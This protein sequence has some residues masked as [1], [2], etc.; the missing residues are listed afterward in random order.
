MVSDIQAGTKMKIEQFIT[1]I[2]FI[3]GLFASACS[4]KLATG[5]EHSIP[6]KTYD[7]ATFDYIYADGIRQKSL[8]NLGDALND[9]EQCLRLNSES[10]ATN[11]EISQIVLGNGDVAN[12]KKYLKR[13]AELDPKNIWYGVALANLYYQNR[14]IDSAVLCYE[15]LIKIYP[16][17][18]N[19]EISLAG[20]YAENK[21]Y[22]EARSILEKFDS[23]YGANE[24]TTLSLVRILIEEKRYQEALNKI[25]D[26]IVQKP[27]DIVYNGIAAEIYRMQGDTQKASDLYSD[28]IKRNPQDPGIQLSLC[29]FLLSKK[30]LDEM[31]I[32]L[33]TIML[34]NEITREQ[35][36]GLFSGL[37][38]NPEIIEKYGK[39][40]EM[41]LMVLEAN[42][43]DDDI[44]ILMRPDFLQKER[45]SE[46]AA[47]RLEEIIGLQPDNYLAW[48]RLLLVYYEM[49]NFEVL[50]K[51]GKECATKFNRSILAK[52]LYANAAMENEEFDTALEELRKA[53]IL[54]GDSKDQE[55]QVLTMRAD[56]YYRMKDFSQAFDTFDKALAVNDTD[57]TV[58]NNYAYYLAEQ[59]THLKDAEKMAKHVIERARSNSTFLDTY[60]WIL[61]KRGKTKEAARIMENIIGAGE[62]KDA[63]YYEHYGFILRRMGKCSEAIKQW[64]NALS[65]DKTKSNLEKEIKDCEK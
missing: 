29:D 9:F 44:I 38:A 48:E 60:A 6:G 39:K 56:I 51:R 42:Y 23:K 64:E 35:K 24:N 55:L 1:I 16:E 25:N 61:Y 14:N 7:Q 52:I 10:D 62:A 33:N 18:E 37:I 45:K 34:N 31:F 13:A 57:L 21:K 63:E 22:N 54:A 49:K 40:M 59:N 12:G 46:D 36:I 28:L 27:N 58:L 50:E 4:K 15:R 30:D 17:K 20:L 47:K 65:L 19:I 2:I 3:S 26:L 43:K 8:G 53:E 41:A 32:L 5:I 11:Y